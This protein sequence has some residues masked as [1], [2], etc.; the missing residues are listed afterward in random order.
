MHAQARKGPGRTLHQ[1]CVGYG[2]AQRNCEGICSLAVQLRVRLRAWRLALQDMHTDTLTTHACHHGALDLML[3]HSQPA[4]TRQSTSKG[5]TP[6]HPP[7]QPARLVAA[8]RAPGPNRRGGLMNGAQRDA[9]WQTDGKQPRRPNNPEAA[10]AAARHC[11]A[12]RAS[13][14]GSCTPQTQ[15]TDE[16]IPTPSAGQDHSTIKRKT[17]PP[18]PSA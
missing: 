9:A 7:R 12:C 4:R 6:T 17:L 10:S 8:V 13:G 11:T 2:M 5:R 14:C 18:C 16:H 15:S 3:E 1:T